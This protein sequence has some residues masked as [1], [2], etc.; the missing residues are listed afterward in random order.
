MAEKRK[1]AES[2][3]DLT[4]DSEDE[5]P[6]AA[7][8]S[9]KVAT[10]GIA[11][12]ASR[13]SALAQEPIGATPKTMRSRE[14]IDKLKQLGAPQR[15]ID[16]CVEKKDLVDLL[17]TYQR[18]LGLPGQKVLAFMHVHALEFARVPFSSAARR[19]PCFSQS[20]CVSTCSKCARVPFSSAAGRVPCF[21]PSA[22]VS[23]C[24]NLRACLSAQLLD[25]FPVIPVFHGV[26]ASDLPRDSW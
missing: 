19:V 13:P 20:V 23:T 25:A 3:I 8:P 2:F 11:S 1:H 21:L 7:T 6:V 18:R 26:H 4:Q 22:R 16:S 14:I 24:S 12:G 5:K 10:N 17:S 15:V 9:K